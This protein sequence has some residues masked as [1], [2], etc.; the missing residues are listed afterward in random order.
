[1]RH[2][3]AGFL[4]QFK[5]L[6]N[7]PRRDLLLNLRRQFLRAALEQ[8]AVSRMGNTINIQSESLFLIEKHG[9]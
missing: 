4:I 2:F 8:I 5:P 7:L 9:V 1:M 6:A 3:A